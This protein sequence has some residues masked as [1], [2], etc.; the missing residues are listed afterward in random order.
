MFNHKDFP[1]LPDKLSARDDADLANLAAWAETLY[2][3]RRIN[4]LILGNPHPRIDVAK[5]IAW[6]K[7]EIEKNPKTRYN[8]LVTP[9]CKID[10]IARDVEH[11]QVIGLKPYQTFSVTGDIA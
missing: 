8:R 10:D 6:T 7:S 5:H 3:G 4:Y 2:P 9:A 11:R 1:D